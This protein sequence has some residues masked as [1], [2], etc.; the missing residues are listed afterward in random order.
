MKKILNDLTELANKLDHMGHLK[1]ASQLDIIIREAIDNNTINQVRKAL[2]LKPGLW[3]GEV[4]NKLKTI[5]PNIKFSSPEGVWKEIQLKKIR[6]ESYNDPRKKP[7]DISK[8]PLK[9]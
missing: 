6:D 4:M 8:V 7:F 9:R 5:H 3:N 2:G 1:E